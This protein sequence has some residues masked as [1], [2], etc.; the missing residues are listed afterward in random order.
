M[1]VPIDRAVDVGTITP[2][3]IE[4]V[5]PLGVTCIEYELAFVHR[6][7]IG[8]KVGVAG[9]TILI[10]IVRVMGQ[11]ITVGVIVQV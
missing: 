2:F 5:P 11:L 4:N 9:L 10:D 6:L 8:T 1:L 7:G 3:G